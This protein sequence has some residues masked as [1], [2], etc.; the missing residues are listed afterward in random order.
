MLSP[1][2]TPVP[3]AK[4]FLDAAAQFARGDDT[5]RAYLERCLDAFAV[6][7]PKIGAFVH[8]N[9]DGARTAADASSRRWR[10]NE[11]LSAI[12][13]MPI[14]IKDIIET[15]DMPTGMGSPLFDGWCSGRD[16]AAVAA[17]REA[18]AV[19]LGKTVTTEF[20]ATEPRGTRN[21]WDLARTPGGSS[22]GSAAA[23]AAGLV[24][25]ALGTQV[26]GSI[27]RPASYCGCVGFKP[28]VGGINRGGSHDELSQSCM[29]VLAATLEDAW[30]VTSE[31][32]ARAG[33]DPGYPGLVGPL[34]VP[35]A[36]KPQRL[37][38]LETAGWK[39][40]S[41]EA[42]Q[43][44]QE[45]MALL[46]RDGIVIVTRRSDGQ[47]GAVEEAIA[48]ARPLSIRINAW[49]S[50]WPLNT[51]RE[52]DASKLSRAMLDR[53]A[54]AE[55]MSLEQYRD[56]LVRRDQARARYAEL[57]AECD[58]CI[59]LS[60]P[61]AAPLGLDSTGDPNCTVHTSL[62]GIPTVSLPVLQD[63]GLPLGL[64]VAGF[65]NGDA[66]VFAVAAAIKALF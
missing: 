55:R 6:W 65:V 28:S 25:A 14:G 9:L 59:S 36:A 50:R 33:G 40:A 53:L 49:E 35:P 32:A 43:A 56:D 17:L 63:E 22:S 39:V 47:V 52:R 57:A 42:K 62:L 58:A 24:S 48:T 46:A 15:A 66:Q 37:V 11:P 60:A 64:Q 21:P 29:G 3:Q 45:S 2:I 19:I 4:P 12:D 18:G 38:F 54:E 23:V 34:R 44:L 7:E 8:T 30:Q 1:D 27:V 13:G 61:A 26:M 51:Y 16:A 20:A 31:I 41:A 10:D 5:P